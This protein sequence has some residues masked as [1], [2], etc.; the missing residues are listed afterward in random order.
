MHE[1]LSEIVFNEIIEKAIS[2]SSHTQSIQ[3]LRAVTS[4]KTNCEYYNSK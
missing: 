4:M 1:E 2:Q 3:A